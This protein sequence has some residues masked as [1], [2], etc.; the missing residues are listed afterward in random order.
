[1]GRIENKKRN[2]LGYWIVIYIGCKVG[3]FIE[4]DFVIMNTIHIHFTP[5]IA[6]CNG[7][8]VCVQDNLNLTKY[9]CTL[10]MNVYIIKK[11]RIFRIYL[12]W[13]G[14]FSAVF[15]RFF[16]I[17]HFQRTKIRT[18]Y[19][20]FKNLRTHRRTDKFPYKCFCWYFIWSRDIFLF[21]VYI[22]V[23]L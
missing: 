23:T 13:V 11:S 7:V 2:V 14:I 17:F 8:N 4:L 19:T 1:M 16:F 9:T 12:T 3:C 15:F 6:F 5:Q 18:K 20:A 22:N 10:F 21:T